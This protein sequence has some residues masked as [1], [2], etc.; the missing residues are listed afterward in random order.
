MTSAGRSP[1]CI[2]P[3]AGMIELLSLSLAL[4]LNYPPF[5]FSELNLFPMASCSDLIRSKMLKFALIN[6]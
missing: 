1:P 3:M 5:E 4:A 2:L 6:L